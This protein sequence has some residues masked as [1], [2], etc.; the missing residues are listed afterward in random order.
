MSEVKNILVLTSIYPA[1][2][3]PKGWTP[4]VHYF[5][6]EWVKQGHR[7]LVVNYQ[8]DRPVPYRESHIGGYQQILPSRNRVVKVTD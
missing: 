2:D 1:D 7:V 3:I 8:A 5:T 6:K 4:V